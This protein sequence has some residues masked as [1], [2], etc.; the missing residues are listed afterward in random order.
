M[1]AKKIVE[2]ILFAAS[3]PIGEEE[4]VA[5][6]VKKTEFRKIINGLI[7]SYRKSAIEIVD[8]DG[9][10]VM[11][12]RN[13]YDKY[14]KTFAPMKLSKSLLK[15]LS[16]IAY[17]QPIKQSELKKIVGSQIY[18]QV[19]ELKKK[20]F[21]NTR[22]AGRTKIIDPSSYFYDYFGFAKNNKEEM[23]SV[24]SKKLGGKG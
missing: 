9:K 23:K 15:T 1:E 10:Y 14:V 12:L 7:K 2:A 6:G 21:V 8:A 4:I 20:G 11:Q 13:D 18:E 5:A 16:I 17:H 24:L 19:K 22:K 3:R